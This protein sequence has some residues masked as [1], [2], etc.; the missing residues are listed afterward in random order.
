M[1][2]RLRHCDEDLRCRGPGAGAGRGRTAREG[3]V[4]C[5]P[6]APPAAPLAR[7][8]RPGR[9]APPGLPPAAAALPAGLGEAAL[10][11]LWLGNG[12]E[13]SSP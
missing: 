10:D 11:L 3:S 7:W 1:V 13:A 8:G 12:S 9:A 6:P 4:W 5:A 2:R